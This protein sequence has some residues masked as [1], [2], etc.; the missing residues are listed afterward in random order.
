MLTDVRQTAL[1]YF[2]VSVH[3]SW[4]FRLFFT[5]IFLPEN[6]VCFMY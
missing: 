6:N 2:L 1:Q 5:V 3:Y 4:Q